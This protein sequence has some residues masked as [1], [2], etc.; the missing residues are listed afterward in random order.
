[1]AI[2]H[3]ATPN[4]S[5]GRRRFRKYVAEREQTLIY[6]LSISSRLKHSMR[7][8]LTLYLDQTIALDM[9]KSRSFRECSI[10][11]VLTVTVSCEDW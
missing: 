8:T 2:I 6:G 4:V 1:M 7:C 9:H 3:V 11:N 10:E 5:E